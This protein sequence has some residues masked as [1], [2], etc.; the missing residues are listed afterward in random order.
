RDDDDTSAER[1]RELPA[2]HRLHRA[3][4]DLGVAHGRVLEHRRDHLARRRDGELH[5]DA[6]TELRLLRQLLL[7]AVLHLVDV[8]PD[9]AADDLLVERSARRHLPHDQLRGLGAT[10]VQGALTEAVAVAEAA[11]T[12]M[13]APL[14]E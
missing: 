13:A 10:G 6:A 5:H 3:V 8:P 14:A 2:P 12:I 11:G 1:L 4:L 7:V 9:D